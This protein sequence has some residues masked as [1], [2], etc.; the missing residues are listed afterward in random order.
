MA[1]RH[2]CKWILAYRQHT[3]GPM[4]WC[5]IQI[6]QPAQADSRMQSI[7]TATSFDELKDGF[8]FVE[9]P[10]PECFDLSKPFQSSNRE[11]MVNSLRSSLTLSQVDSIELASER[12]RNMQVYATTSDSDSASTVSSLP[13]LPSTHGRTCSTQSSVDDPIRFVELAPPADSASTDDSPLAHDPWNGECTWITN[14]P[15]GQ[16]MDLVDTMVTNFISVAKHATSTAKAIFHTLQA[17]DEPTE[18]TA[19]SSQEKKLGLI[20]TFNSSQSTGES[21]FEQIEAS[22]TSISSMDPMKTLIAMGFANRAKNQRL[23]REND[24]DLTRVIEQLTLDVNED[25]DWFAHR[26]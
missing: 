11:S 3:F 13:L 22:A 4:I 21:F 6:G 8:E 16:P 24:D 2:E 25:A 1:E 19:S 15:S 26:H 17:T 9:V 12:L 7:A 5:S 18:A 14:D 10:L 23:L 20:N